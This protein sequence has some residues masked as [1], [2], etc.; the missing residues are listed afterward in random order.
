MHGANNNLEMRRRFFDGRW[1][2]SSTPFAP[3]ERPDFAL[4]SSHV[5]VL[6][7]RLARL[8]PVTSHCTWGQCR[9]HPF[10]FPKC[11]IASAFGRAQ[12]EFTFQKLPLACTLVAT[13]WLV[14]AEGQLVLTP[15]RRPQAA[16]RHGAGA[17]DRHRQRCYGKLS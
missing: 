13:R 9:S 5:N 14:K 15:S 16:L 4:S 11:C 12:R 1:G 7:I 10:A 3:T 6:L 2:P 8:E 17:S